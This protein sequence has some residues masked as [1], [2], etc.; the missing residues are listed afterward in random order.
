MG[1]DSSNRYREKAV[2]SL[3]NLFFITVSFFS[4]MFAVI[5]V[6]L[7]SLV[8]FKCLGETF[9]MNFVLSLCSK[10]IRLQEPALCVYCLKHAICYNMLC[11]F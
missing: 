9:G 6:L 5:D 11:G 3:R 10:L 8:N 4:L 7:F 1:A 2:E